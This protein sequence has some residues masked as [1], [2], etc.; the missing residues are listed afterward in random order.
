M[1]AVFLLILALLAQ[2]GLA[3]GFLWGGP[4]TV[5]HWLGF[6]YVPPVYHILPGDQNNCRNCREVKDDVE[7]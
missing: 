5:F 1:T 6:R 7:L 4:L 2:Q 3:L